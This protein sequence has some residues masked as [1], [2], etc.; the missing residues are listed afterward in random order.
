MPYTSVERSRESSRRAKQRRRGRCAACGAE[1]RYNGHTVKG[2]SRL[3]SPC[4][5]VEV[6]KR[7]RGKGHRGQEVLAFIGDGRR[8]YTEIQ[9]HLGITKAHTSS[10]LNRMIAY[11]L[12]ER[13]DRGLYQ[14]KTPAS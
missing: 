1:T 12:L 4:A 7:L 5:A 6:G 3:C 11:G 9:K 14:T 10:L 13:V 8:R 2:P